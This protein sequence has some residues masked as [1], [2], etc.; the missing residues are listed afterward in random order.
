MSAHQKKSVNVKTKKQKNVNQKLNIIIETQKCYDHHKEEFINLLKIDANV[1]RKGD[2]C[3]L[4]LLFA[5]LNRKPDGV[6]FLPINS[7]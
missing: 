4:S 3:Q 5:V 1:D 6:Q 2:E 7:L